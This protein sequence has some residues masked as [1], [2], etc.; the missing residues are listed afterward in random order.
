MA[1]K[2]SN[3]KPVAEVSKKAIVKAT[4]IEKMAPEVVKSSSDEPQILHPA[5]P[6]KEQKISRNWIHA[7]VI[8]IPKD[9]GMRAQLL[10]KL[11]VGALIL[12]LF[13]VIV[14][15]VWSIGDAFSTNKWGWFI[16]LPIQFQVIIIAV[17][18][19]AAFG[20]LFGLVVLYRHGRN[21]VLKALY[22][23]IVPSDELKE[24]GDHKVPRIVVSL[25]MM[26]ALVLLAGVVI[27]VIEIAAT[28]DLNLGNESQSFNDLTG[29]EKLLFI[30]VFIII[31]TGSLLGSLFLL[32]TG[33]NYIMVRLARVNKKFKE[34]SSQLE[35]KKKELSSIFYLA[36]TSI[37]IAITFGT[38][39]WIWDTVTPNKTPWQAFLENYN[40]GLKIG[41]VG[42][43]LTIIFVVLLVFMMRYYW[44]RHMIDHALFERRFPP[45]ATN[46]NLSTKIVTGGMVL[47]AY[48]I[49]LFLILSLLLFLASPINMIDFLGFF[50]I[51]NQMALGENI[52]GYSGFI[53]LVIILFLGSVYFLFNGYGY[54]LKEFKHMEEHTNET[55]KEIIE[56]KKDTAKPSST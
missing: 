51:L 23:K 18:A 9:L 48:I 13:V 29:G 47:T 44:I 3:V 50:N 16:G 7:P 42:I 54:L 32:Q 2:K 22:G 49:G 39:W 15:M 14:G 20:I 38:I 31:I 4:E 1:E 17:I 27:A 11:F 34:D 35:I 5:E 26:S 33:Y 6:L 43:F 21:A 30:M 24:F 46:A 55:A 36:I 37:V 19:L 8:S 10:A 25:T 52:I 40:V 28:G 45:S 41:L 56:R 12:E 53:L